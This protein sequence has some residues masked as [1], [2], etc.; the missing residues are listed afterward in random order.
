MTSLST[1]AQ[2][3]SIDFTAE[4]DYVYQ[5]GVNGL[6]PI[7]AVI[8]NPTLNSINDIQ[9]LI[10]MPASLNLGNV[11]TL[12]DE[13]ADSF[14]RTLDCRI[15][16]L[17]AQSSRVVDFFIDGP[18]SVT[19][20]PQFTLSLSS[21][22]ITVL[23]PDAVEVS[24]ADGNTRIRGSNLDIKLVRDIAVDFN[25]NNVP[26][27]DEAIIDLPPGTP[28]DELLAR[29]AVVDIL[30]LY[31]PAAAQYL[32]GKLESRVG[33]F[34][35]VSNQ[36]FRE[37]DVNIKFNGAGLAEVPYLLT[38][39]TLPDTFN[40]LQSKT[41][42]AFELVDQ[43]LLSSGGDL[44]VFLHAMDPGIDPLCGYASINALGRQGDFQPAYHRGELITVVNIGPGRTV[45]ACLTWLRRLLQTWVSC[46][47][48]ANI[49]MVVLSP[50]PRVTVSPMCLLP[51]RR[52][53]GLMTG[54]W[55]RM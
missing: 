7:V 25:Q 18:N 50:I 41:D 44:I 54:V 35:T 5:T 34:V 22:S 31:S 6:L 14:T 13:S 51:S 10:R 36:V 2:S 47:I 1:V 32:D 16:T 23:E 39:S 52:G 40:A 55:P 8:S 53:W 3:P 19:A 33:Q 29:D 15:T 11:D 17:K 30:F 20:G 21:T 27:I 46:L 12:C 9:F 4:R 37:N 49:Q 45:S 26:D 24:L 48:E 38:D 43:M 42:P 28:V